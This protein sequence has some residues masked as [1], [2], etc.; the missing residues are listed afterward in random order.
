MPV[1]MPS[2]LQMPHLIVTRK[3]KT[4]Q[5]SRME[6][7]IAESWAVVNGFGGHNLCVPLSWTVTMINVHA[8]SAFICALGDLT[9]WFSIARIWDVC[10]EELPKWVCERQAS[11]SVYICYTWNGPHQMDSPKPASPAAPF[12]VAPS[13]SKRFPCSWTRGLFVPTESTSC[14]TYDHCQQ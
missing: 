3:C 6:S 7:C 11:N 10:C 5:H 9:W 2:K 8:A 14:T 12:P 1:I 4:L 13:F